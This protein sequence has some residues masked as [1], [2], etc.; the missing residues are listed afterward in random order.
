MG[1]DEVSFS[2]GAG[3]IRSP[4]QRKTYTPKVNGRARFA[5]DERCDNNGMKHL[6]ESGGGYTGGLG[7]A[8]CM[9]AKDIDGAAI[10]GHGNK[11]PRSA[12]FSKGQRAGCVEERGFSPACGWDLSN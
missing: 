12:T 6:H 3:G 5:V 8:V 9:G 4:F 11:L 1:F 10:D 2:E 7:Y